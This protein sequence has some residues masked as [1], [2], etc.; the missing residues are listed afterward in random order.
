MSKKVAVFVWN[1]F[2]NDARVWRECTALQAAGYH[3]D[4]IALQ[5]PKQADLAK[6]E[7]PLPNLH[8][9]RVS[10]ELP[11]PLIP[12]ARWL[13]T[14]KWAQLFMSAVALV[15]VFFQP[16]LFLL[17]AL[18]VGLLAWRK[19]RTVLRRCAIFSRMVRQGMTQKYDIYHANDLNTLPQ[20]V[21]C[22]KLFRRKPLI[23]DSH[24]VQTSRTGYDSR[25]YG[26]SEKWLLRFT[27]VCIHENHTR[28][29]Y[30]EETYHFYPKVVHNYADVFQPDP[31]RHIDLHDMLDIPTEEPILL[32]QG[33]VQIGRGLDKLIQAIPFFQRGVVVI[34]GD[35]RI[36]EDLQ[37]QAKAM[38]LDK[39]IRFLPKVPVT[40]L[41]YYTQ[42]AYLGFQLLNNVCFNHYSASSNK[43]FE[44]IMCQVPVIGAD[45]PEIKKVIQEEKI[46][47]TVD[48]HSPVAIAHAV[49]RLLGNP[50]LR[51]EL[52]HHC[53]QA[54]EKYNWNHEKRLFLEIYEEL[55]DGY[56]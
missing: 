26:I 30:I 21:L 39:R 7:A 33:G 18:L 14:S 5:D 41:L 34:L 24:E 13:K 28:A 29:S 3:V 25:L 32:Y 49:N 38:C 12:M 2:T 51:D 43:L 46:G 37:Q 35:G 54:R 53:L 11:W 50:A 23:Y 47:L 6:Q 15:L 48:S 44:Y 27:D 55:E 17:C 20:A 36:K 56:D 9:F 52:S 1:H 4:I 45:F 42:N 16:W 8:I 40:E 22:A 19:T 31:C 10:S